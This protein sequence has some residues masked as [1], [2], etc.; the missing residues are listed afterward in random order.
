MCG[1]VPSI[2]RA[3]QRDDETDAN[4]PIA[5]KIIH[6]QREKQTN[7]LRITVM[8]NVTLPPPQKVVTHR[9]ILQV[10]SMYAGIVYIFTFDS[11]S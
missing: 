10:G 9:G 11:T 7:N 1:T 2:V 6:I 8:C 4:K 5:Y 3:Q